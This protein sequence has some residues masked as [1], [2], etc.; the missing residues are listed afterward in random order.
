MEFSTFTEP[1]CI[2]VC[3]IAICSIIAHIGVYGGGGYPL[4]SLFA[5]TIIAIIA[6][7]SL[8]LINHGGRK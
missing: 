3:S 6:I 1:V 4:P 2:T 7:I 5:N 8:H